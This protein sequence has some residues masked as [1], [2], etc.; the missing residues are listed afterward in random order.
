MALSPATSRAASAITWGLALPSSPA[1]GDVYGLTDSLTAP[2]YQW[3]CQYDASISGTAKWRVIGGAP[4][5]VEI[6]TQQ[7]NNGTANQWNNLSTVGPDFGPLPHAGTFL[8]GWAA[9]FF[10]GG[11]DVSFM[12]VANGNNTPFTSFSA[13]SASAASWYATHAHVDLATRAAGET[14][15]VRYFNTTRTDGQYDSRKLTVTPILLG[16]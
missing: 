9:K 15:R 6:E 12:G 14:F 4:A 11:V 2:T 1:T 7:T 3:V 16:P 8:I 13:Y 5:V 10:A